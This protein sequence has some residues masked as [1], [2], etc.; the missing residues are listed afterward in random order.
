MFWIVGG[1]GIIHALARLAPR[2]L[3][4][5]ID[6]Q[7]VHR[8][9]EGVTFYDLIFP[10][11]VF[12]VGVSLVFSLGKILEQKGRAAAIKRIV[13]R[14]ALLFVIGVLYSSNP[15]S[16]LEGIRLLGVLQ[17]IALCYLFA[18]I[19]FCAL[20][21]RGLVVVC[22]SLLV[23]Y[24]AAMTFIPIPGVGAGRYAEGENLANYI[25]RQYLPFHKY[26]GDHDPEGLL[27]TL[28]AVSTCLLGVFAGKLLHDRGIPERRKVAWLLVAGGAGIALGSL[29][30]TQFPVVKK[31]LTSSYVLVTAGYSCLFLA[32]FHQ[33]IEVWGLRAWAG[34]FLWIGRNPITMYLFYPVLAGVFWGSMGSLEGSI[35]GRWA[36]LCTGLAVIGAVLAVAYL[37]DRR[38]IYLRL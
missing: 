25:D 7:F 22:L 10:L 12:I 29:W 20:R 15:L 38:K 2:G 24:W 21:T 32:A 33:V 34:P 17:R 19:L 36:E 6:G 28:P 8:S 31:I 35:L 1:E 27:S 4:A 37:L 23:G 18:G 3:L 5:A 16:G 13:R 30:G 14:S 26:D 9:W 11:F